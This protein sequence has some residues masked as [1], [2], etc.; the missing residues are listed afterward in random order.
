MHKSFQ[1]VFES[2]VLLVFFFLFLL[3]LKDNGS[4]TQIYLARFFV[5]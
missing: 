1:H 4:A 5:F 3:V 2:P